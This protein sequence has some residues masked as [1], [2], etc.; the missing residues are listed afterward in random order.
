MSVEAVVEH[1]SGFGFAE[2]VRTFTESTATVAEAAAALGVA[3]EQIAKT[4]S[5]YGKEPGSVVLV[6]TAGDARL[7]S[8]PF[9]RR[10]GVKPSMLKADEVEP[11]TGHAI[12][13]VCPFAVAPGTT[14]VL[15]ESLRRFDVVYPAA[16][17]RNAAAR[18]SVAE[19]E[20]TL[21]G[22]EWV[23]VCKDWREAE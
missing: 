15:D 14:I 12:G 23:D 1:L 21:P 3:P 13:G 5:V 20:S 4:I 10:F 11:L 9:K 22:V 6:V 18:L 2:R 17:A 19:L 7:S 16:G 8:G